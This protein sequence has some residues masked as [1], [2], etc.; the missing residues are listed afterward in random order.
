MTF[1][2]GS[3]EFFIFE[4]VFFFAIVYGLFTVRGSGISQHPYRS[5]Y[6]SCSSLPSDASGSDRHSWTRGTRP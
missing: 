3:T 5:P 4:I 6:T 1:T 2:G